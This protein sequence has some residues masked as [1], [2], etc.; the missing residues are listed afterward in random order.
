M[1]GSLLKYI[2]RNFCLVLIVF[3]TLAISFQKII[4]EKQRDRKSNSL[5][6]YNNYLIFKQSSVHF[7]EQKDIYQPHYDEC[8]DDYKYSPAFAL[9]FS[10][11]A[12]LPDWLGLILWNLLNALVFF[13]ALWQF[14][15]SDYKKKLLA[16][17]F[18]LIELTT[19][20]H[21][22]QS[23]GLIAGLLLFSFILFERKRF[24]IGTLLIA[25]S[26]Y[27]KLF[28]VVAFML[29]L[30]YP[31]R[32]RASLYA[33]FWMVSLA[34]LPLL[35]VSVSQL[36]LLYQSWFHLLQKDPT[37]SDGFSVMGLLHSWFHIVA[38]K[39][40]VVLPGAILLSLPLLK[41]PF[42]KEACFRI[43]MLSSVLI[44]VVI[45][46]H[47]AESPTFIIAVAGI[48]VWF[49]SKLKTSATDLVLL[50]GAFLIT[51]LSPTDIFPRYVR[52][53]YIIPYSLKALP[54]ILIWSKI[55]YEQMFWKND[56]NKPEEASETENIII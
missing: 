10:V 11:F 39:I 42:Y 27:I 38:D 32:W 25:L 7:F 43:L 15:F 36:S 55:L 18:T 44:W 12:I 13:F 5:S 37:I 31:E 28:G 47:K 4:Q 20:L 49:F 6:Y 23:N 54:C 53:N 34:I 46:N 45:F 52:E 29:V 26:V 56:I 2:N 9:F 33:L 8:W 1:K 19:S 40:W 17:A 50:L 51:V 3:V 22:A 30:L 35:V 14:P 48:A 21:N 41:F 24:F 16:L